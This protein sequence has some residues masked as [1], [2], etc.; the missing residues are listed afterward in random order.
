M[1]RI[2]PRNLVSLA[3][4]LFGI[5]GIG[6]IV[7]PGLFS[8]THSAAAKAP[9]GLSPGDRPPNFTLQTSTGQTVSVR[10]LQGKPVWLNFWATW[11]PWCRKEIPLIEHVK[12][13][14]G[15]RIAIYGVD[16]QQSAAQVNHY[17]QIEK[18]NYP[19]LLDR[20]GSVAAQYGVR[21]FPTS[22]FIGR[23]GT[24]QAVYTG[25]FLNRAAMAPFIKQ[26][27]GY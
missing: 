20:T 12:S 23:S 3:V 7:G 4:L 27:V 17:R 2:R 16:V 8:P 19:V 10:S 11:C 9:V 18:M 5:G 6:A 25:A 22:I 26:L 15:H 21:A 24:I 13:Q 1:T 14:Y